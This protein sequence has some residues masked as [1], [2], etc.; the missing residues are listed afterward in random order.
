[1]SPTPY[2]V[3][4]GTL[5]DST[6]LSGT[7]LLTAYSS[8]SPYVLSVQACG[9]QCMATATCT[10]IYFVAGSSCNLHYGQMSYVPNNSGVNAYSIYNVSCFTDSYLASPAPS[11]AVCNVL[12]DSVALT[13]TGL[14]VAYTGASGS[15]YVTSIQACATQC[16]STSTCTNFYFVNGTSCNLHYGANS[17]VVNNSGVNAYNFYDLTCFKSCPFPTPYQTGMATNCNKFH[18]VVS[19]DECGAIATSAGITL[20]NFYSWNPAVGSTCATLDLGDYVCIGVS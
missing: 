4:C 8:G 15:P 1:V 17:Y 10:N 12:A 14:L 2:G 16:F 18:F 6:A 20:A 11:G 9:A 13:G 5:G 3:V 7:G 19:G